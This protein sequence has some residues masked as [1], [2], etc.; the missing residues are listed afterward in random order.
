[1]LQAM[2]TNTVLPG[3]VSAAGTMPAQ[4]SAAEHSAAEHSAEHSAA[5]HRRAQHRTA[6][7]HGRIDN[8]QQQT[9]CKLGTGRLALATV[10][11]R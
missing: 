6:E 9:Y 4:H 10:H 7:H 5:E 1:M 11:A 8:T 3:K 2:K